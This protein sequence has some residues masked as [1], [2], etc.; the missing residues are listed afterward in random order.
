MVYQNKPPEMLN[1]GSVISYI[2]K[3]EKL[4][5]NLFLHKILVQIRKQEQRNDSGAP[6]RK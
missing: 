1:A 6:F 2:E 3:N 5:D 4:K